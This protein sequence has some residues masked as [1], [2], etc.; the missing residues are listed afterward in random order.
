MFV[1]AISM[2]GSVT[3]LAP[4]SVPTSCIFTS[5]LPGTA[6][7]SFLECHNTRGTPFFPSIPIFS[8]LLFHPLSILPDLRTFCRFIG[9]TLFFY[10]VS[11][12]PPR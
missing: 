5:L 10:I 4:S 12:P 3:A 11:L 2:F 9:S 6:I 8:S 7:C 1:I